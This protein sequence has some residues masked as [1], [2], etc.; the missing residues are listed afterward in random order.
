MY[1]CSEVMNFLN[2]VS[3]QYPSAD[4]LASG[5]PNEDHFD[6]INFKQYEQSFIKYFSEKKGI[7]SER[8]EKL[9]YQYGPTAGIANEI[10]KTYLSSQFEISCE[11]EQ[12]IITNGC[13]EALTLLIIEFLKAESDYI[14]IPEPSYI[15]ISGI[16]KALGKNMK[17]VSMLRYDHNVNQYV[18]D[19]NTLELNILSL[20]NSNKCPKLIYL[21]LDFNNPLGFSVSEQ[22]KL[23]LLALCQKHDIAII[24]DN[25]YGLFNFAEQKMPTL[26]S[27]DSDNRVFYIDSFAKTL[28]PALRVGCLVCPLG[29][30]KQVKSL[31]ELKSFVSVNTSQLSQSIITGFLLTNSFNFKGKL[32]AANKDY[33]DRRNAMLSA[34]EKHFGLLENVSWNTPGGGFFLVINTPWEF[35]FNDV[36]ECARDFGVIFMPV[37]FFANEDTHW[38]KV[39][40]LAYSNL[41]AAQI[42]VAVSKLAKFLVHKQQ[43]S[44]STKSEIEHAL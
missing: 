31:I 28:C 23:A 14:L 8:A 34:L 3:Y 41:D 16:V 38:S 4:S 42:E 6:S 30:E 10:F 22:D 37:S 1:K 32:E 29:R 11:S 15:G 25:P 2:E 21:N 33:L 12:I 18:L 43:T 44:Q 9:L 19:L 39:I 7:Q 36:E 35:T 40:R 26:K 5:R 17:P 24:E 27:L 20:R 13:Q